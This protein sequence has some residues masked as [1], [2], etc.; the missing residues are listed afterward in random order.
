ME[1]LIRAIAADGSAI[2]IAVDSTDMI[3]RAERIHRTSAAVTAAMGR[4][5][6]AASIMGSMLK[7]EK[8]SVTLRLSG[9]GPVESIISVAEATGDARCYVVNPI[10]ELPL[11]SHG[12]LNV[13][14]VV[15]T[16]GF[17]TV[18][19]DV[20]LPEFMTGHSPIVS[21]EVAEDIAYYYATSEQIPTV[22]G[23]GVLVNPDLSVKS[24]G[25]YLVQLLPGADEG[26]IDKIEANIKKMPPVSKMFAEGYTPERVIE[27]ALAGFNP[28]I[29]DRREVGYE[30]NCSRE[31][32]ERALISI[33][34]ADLEKLA[35][36]QSHTE[37]DCHFCNKK[38]RFSKKELLQ[39]AASSGGGE[40]R[41][42]D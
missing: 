19:K 31:R 20:G 2:C 6:T 28:E 26:T 36:E 40:S 39:L 7:E 9:D 14:G 12:K 37:V 8:G 4:L 11:N 1:N 30:C 38:H 17:L 18:I 13:A 41:E 21:G 29:I 34:K 16:K 32:V 5:T 22:C 3:K 24:A 33:G 15:G 10:V 25:G 35:Q 23:L 42:K 27:E